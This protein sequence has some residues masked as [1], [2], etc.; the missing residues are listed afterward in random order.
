MS[1]AIIPLTPSEVAVQ[2]TEVSKENFVMRDL[3]ALDQFGN[4]LTG[5][6]MDETISSR[7]AID[8]TNGK[9]ISEKVGEAGSKVL[10]IFQKDHG[11]KA[12]AGDLERATTE[13]SIEQSTGTLL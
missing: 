8:A 7:L 2:E 13:V 6:A 4:V 10:D 12:Q 11:A 9:G 3:V 1:D 5:G